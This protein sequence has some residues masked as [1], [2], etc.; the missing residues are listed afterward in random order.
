MMDPETKENPAGGPEHTLRE[1]LLLLL[2]LSYFPLSWLIFATWFP[3]RME[4]W[5]ISVGSYTLISL[6][7]LMWSRRDQFF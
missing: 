4:T 2:W 5:S 6:A 7:G 3:T 1:K